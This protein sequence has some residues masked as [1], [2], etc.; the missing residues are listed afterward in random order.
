MIGAHNQSLVTNV[1]SRN[2]SQAYQCRS[3]LS[4]RQEPLAAVFAGKVPVEP[5][6]RTA[7]AIDGQSGVVPDD[8]DG[9]GPWSHRLG[10]Q[11]EDG[12]VVHFAILLARGQ[13]I[14]GLAQLQ[15]SGASAAV[16]WVPWCTE[17]LP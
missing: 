15:A 4:K 3:R 6:H 1:I 10:S 16:S 2:V 11:G 14:R 8:D 9:Q 13:R 12:A 17:Y 7:L 5:C